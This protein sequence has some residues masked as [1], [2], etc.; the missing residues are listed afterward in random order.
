MI[1]TY[2]QGDG[3]GKGDRG[4]QGAPGKLGLPGQPGRDG[5]PGLTGPQVCIRTLLL[6]VTTSSDF[7]TL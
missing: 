6:C 4:D 3:G 1:R 2:M 5:S 7:V